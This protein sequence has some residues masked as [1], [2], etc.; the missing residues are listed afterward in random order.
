MM[1]R[2]SHFTL[3]TMLSL[4][5]VLFYAL[6]AQGFTV[7][8]GT[9]TSKLT[10]PS[11]S[12]PASH[13]DQRG[14]VRVNE[15]GLQR[16]GFALSATVAG[17]DEDLSRGSVEHVLG[18]NAAVLSKEDME[19]ATVLLEL[20]QGH[21]FADWP[22]PG[23]EDEGKRKLLAQARACSDKYPGGLRAYVTKARTLLDES[24]R[25]VNPFL[26]FTPELP[27]GTSLEYGT[28]EYKEAEKI[29]M[30][31][32]S[33]TGFV[34]VAGGLGER[35]GYNGIK[36][37]L[38]VQVTTRTCYLELYCRYIL[39]LQERCGG[40]LELPLIIMTSQ[41]TDEATRA[42]LADNNNF[43]MKEGQI[44]V[45]MQDKVP[46]LGDSTAKLVTSGDPYELETKPH[47]HGDVHQLLHREGIAKSLL[48]QG[49]EYLFFFQDTNALVLNSILPALGVS[50]SRGFDMNSICVPRKAKEAAGAITSLQHE[51][52]S[53]LI[54]NV[55]YNQLDPLL[56]ATTSP[57]GDVNDPATGYSPFP[58]NTNQ[59][60]FELSSYCKV[61]EGEDMG[62][63]VEFVNPKY[64]DEERVQFKKPT[65][66]ECMMQDFP[67]LM[68][69]ELDNPNIGYTSLDKWL[70]FSPAKNSLDAGAESAASGVPPGTASTAEAEYYEQCVRRL[71]ASTGAK[72]EASGR[73]EFEGVPFDLPPRVVLSPSFAVCSEDLEKKV[74]AGLKVSSRSTLVIDGADIYLEDLELDGALIIKA[75]PG[76]MVAVSGLKVTN[77]GWS[78]EAI[79]EGADVSEED[80]I[81]GFLLKKAE[82]KVI[83]VTEPGNWVIGVTGIASKVHFQPSVVREA[84]A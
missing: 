21:L 79:P 59:I 11:L 16:E 27:E 24:A 82:T 77:E 73:V 18:G 53:S 41:D 64:K 12:S 57:E 10:T 71:Q 45:I 37:S 74:S 6:T 1:T 72:I 19:M 61:L 58:G 31:A 17:A 5:A 23:T 36:L 44:Q 65:R 51:D 15:E 26:G 39:A 60:V 20:G 67:K 2:L 76:A 29:G 13:A 8:S 32:V 55:E 56:R 52:G 14:G 66:L 43:G 34:L 28:I 81:R 48:G 4:A 63:V 70:S 83:E 78:M 84:A 7:P 42:L 69:K 46:A 80:R 50:K 25:G 40:S 68:S 54:I 62:V 22:E 30:E 38:P 35:L 3:S 33:K 9:W 49:F 47:G 75:V